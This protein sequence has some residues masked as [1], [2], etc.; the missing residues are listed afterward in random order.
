LSWQRGLG[1]VAGHFLTVGFG[2]GTEAGGWH[3]NP[4]ISSTFQVS[5]ISGLSQ[6]F[7]DLKS[8]EELRMFF[9]IHDMDYLP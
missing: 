3:P 6:Y 9:I 1:G 7:N 5:K 2:H 8:A 4:N